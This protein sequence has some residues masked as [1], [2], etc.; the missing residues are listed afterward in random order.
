[1]IAA[2]CS[3]LDF[4]HRGVLLESG[5]AVDIITLVTTDRAAAAQILTTIVYQEKYPPV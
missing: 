4:Y 2:C 3:T 1:M 5:H